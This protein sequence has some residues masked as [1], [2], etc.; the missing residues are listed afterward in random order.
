MD[1]HNKPIVDVL[2][3]RRDLYFLMSLLLADK[4]VDEKIPSAVVWTQIFYDTEVT[5]LALWVATAMRSLL[6]LSDGKKMNSAN[7][8]AGNTGLIFQAIQNRR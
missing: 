2:T 4:A 7:N 1:N 5:R 3:V 6:D 8:A